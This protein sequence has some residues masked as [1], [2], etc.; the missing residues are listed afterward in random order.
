M[1][2]DL[3][4]DTTIIYR[5]KSGSIRASVESIDYRLKYERKSGI[6]QY[7]KAKFRSAKLQSLIRKGLKKIDVD[8][9]Y[10]RSVPKRVCLFHIEKTGFFSPLKKI[11][12]QHSPQSEHLS[13]ICSW[14]SIYLPTSFDYP[15]FIKDLNNE[16]I[17][18]GSSTLL[19]KELQ[20]IQNEAVKSPVD[21][22]KMVS[23]CKITEQDIQRS[24]ENYNP[25][26]FWLSFSYMILHK[27]ATESLTSRLPIIID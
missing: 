4:N 3:P 6:Y 19:L 20:K 21:L 23:F 7:I 12:Q 17:A 25:H 10:D 18:I 5:K 15:F 1:L 2:G 13:N 9:E 11:V 8:Y 27:L 14:N 24:E 22:E 16:Q 26:D